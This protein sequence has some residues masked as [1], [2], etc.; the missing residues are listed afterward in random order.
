MPPDHNLALAVHRHSIATPD[1][2]CVA[3]NKSSLTYGEVARRAGLLSDC[4]HQNAR[5]DRVNGE[6]PRIG[7]L[8][9]RSIDACVGVLGACWAGA[10]YVPIGP[11]LPEERVLAILAQCNLSALI[12]APEGVHLLTEKVLAAGPPLIISPE[13]GTLTRVP[14]GVT[15][16][17][18]RDL[19]C[20]PV[21]V[22]TAPA[23]MQ[24]DDTAYII[25]TSGTTGVPK[26]VMIA[27][28]AV[29]AFLGTMSDLLVLDSSDRVLETCELTFD[30][31]VH[32]MFVTWAAGASLYV[33]PP[34]QVMNAVKFVRTHQ[35]TVWNSVPSLIGMLRQIKALAPGSMPSMRKALFAGESLTTGIVDSWRAAAPDSTVYDLYGPTEATVFCMVQIVGDPP[36]LTPGR[37]LIAI[38]K[39]LPGCE[40]GILDEKGN[41]VADATHGELAIA[42]VQL[43]KGYLSAPEK[44]RQQFPVIDGKRWYLTG[45]I[46]MRDA[47]GV[48]HC[49]GRIDNQVKVLGNRVELEEIEAH[50]R[51][52]TQ[53]EMVG[54]VAYPVVDGIAQGVVGFIGAIEVDSPKVVAELKMRLPSYMVPS[55]V[56]AL[57]RM[58][59]NQ[60][61]KVDRRAL[62]QQLGEAE[63]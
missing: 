44:T 60:S 22:A 47:S 14:T 53:A 43:A 45:D 50:L 18:A 2:I 56:I 15:V 5:L 32:N 61:G 46:G 9:T 26:G 57:E 25:F 33:L 13:A 36:L 62:R 16:V 4:L 17:D 24:A 41:W 42:G 38:G 54:V 6:P 31:S 63:S 3:D 7:V 10:T 48:F 49:F 59:T 8:G 19:F 29:N 52:V 40:A 1:A 23:A 55:K 27:Y 51:K 21:Q 35:L 12:V 30:V 20:Q 58:P 28:S 34:M 39:A 11:K 37:D